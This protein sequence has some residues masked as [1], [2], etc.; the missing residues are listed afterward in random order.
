MSFKPD[1]RQRAMA[2]IVCGASIVAVT[3]LAQSDTL[4]PS[5]GQTQGPPA[6]SGYG[7]PRRGGPDQRAE[8]LTRQLGLN[9]DQTTQV[10]AL[11]E[12]ERSQMQTLHS[13]TALT[14]EDMHAQMMALHQSSDAKLRAMLT[15][16]QVTR[17]DAMQQ[18]MR[19]RMQERQEDGQGAPP[20]P[21]GAPQQ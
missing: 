2:L 1:I 6:G 3:C 13:N 4:P 14:R 7:G 20:P 17:Y 10:K 12:T 19:A 9:P 16:D 21:A 8:M 5:P 15:P 18:R 11:L